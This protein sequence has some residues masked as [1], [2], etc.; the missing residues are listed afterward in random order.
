MKTAD[1]RVTLIDYCGSDL[2]VVNAAR[3]SFDKESKYEMDFDLDEKGQTIATE[4]LALRDRKLIS[5][6]A[7]HKHTSPFNH[8]FA[9]FRV[10]APIFVARQLV[11]HKFLPWNEVSRRYVDSEPEFFIPDRWRLRA[12][13]VKQGSSE[14]SREIVNAK[15]RITDSKNKNQLRSPCAAKFANMKAR[16]KREGRDWEMTEEDIEWPLECPILSIPL[17]YSL[18]RGGIYYDSPSI[19]RIDP[20][21]GY[22]KGN[23]RIISSLANTMKSNADEETLVTFARSILLQY[24]GEIARGPSVEDVV[25]QSL[26]T[27]NYLLN[28]AKVAPEMA[29]MILPQNTMTEWIWSGTL[30]AW[31][32]MCRLRLDPHAQVETRVV[33]EAISKEMCSLFPESWKA[34]LND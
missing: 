10:K 23:T 26:D 16:A 27:Y 13:N 5:Y 25:Q 21:K 22:V 1:I 7:K 29:R 14:E 24:R 11:K 17:N 32:D 3:V 12:E 34:L 18:G 20:S 15:F 28:E 4:V 2:S 8:C 9:S 19:D 31:A 6:L 30:G 33:A